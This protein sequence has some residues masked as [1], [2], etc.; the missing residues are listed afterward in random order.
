MYSGP[1][2]TTSPDFPIPDEMK[3]WVLGDPGELCFA[4]QQ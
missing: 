3:A 4:D 1:F 2:V